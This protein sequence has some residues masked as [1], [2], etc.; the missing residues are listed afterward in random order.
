MRSRRTWLEEG[1]VNSKYFLNLEKR[2]T[3]L[4]SLKRLRIDTN[5]TSDSSKISQFVI[6]F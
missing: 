5:I 2:N 1:E 3:E 4:S 6:S